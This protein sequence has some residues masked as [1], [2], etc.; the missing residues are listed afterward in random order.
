M[1]I[2]CF[3]M[4]DDAPATLVSLVDMARIK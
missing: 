1:K 4:F 2:D 3:P